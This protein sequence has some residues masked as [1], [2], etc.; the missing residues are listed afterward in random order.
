MSQ[1]CNTNPVV[2]PRGRNKR[3]WNTKEK[4]KLS[5]LT[6]EVNERYRRLGVL[7][8]AV[9]D[10]EAARIAAYQQRVAHYEETFAQNAGA[11]AVLDPSH[12][13]KLQNFIRS[14][15]GAKRTNPFNTGT[16]FNQAGE[17]AQNLLD[18]KRVA[19]GMVNDAGMMRTL[20]RLNTTIDNIRA[21]L[22]HKGIAPDKLGETVQDVIEM[23]NIPKLRLAF[24]KSD[25]VEAFQMKRLGD[26]YQR[27]D[28]LGFDGAETDELVKMAGDVSASFD[29]MRAV[30]DSVGYNIPEL[31]NLGYF[32]RIATDDWRMRLKQHGNEVAGADLSSKLRSG[33]ILSTDWDK[34]RN[35]YWYVPSDSKIA[36]EFLRITPDELDAMILDPIAFRN[37]LGENTTE[38]Q[39][40]DLFDSGVMSKLPMSGRETFEYFVDKFQLPYKGLNEMFLVDPKRAIEAY[41]NELK[42]AVGNHAMVKTVISD[43]IDA[44]WILPHNTIQNLPV[45]QQ[46]N[47]VRL[48]SLEDRLKSWYDTDTLK[49]LQTLYVHRTVA[50]QWMSILHI[51][52]SPSQLGNIARVW[53]HITTTLN[54]SALLGTN[55]LYLGR[56]FLGAV[57]SGH[58]AGADLTKMLPAMWDVANLA[59]KGLEHFDNT[60]PFLKADGK[61]MT[62]REAVE[63]FMLK[64][65]TDIVPGTP[66]VKTGGGF[67]KSDLNPLHHIMSAKKALSDLYLY[68]RS[69]GDPISGAKG[70]T[71]YS[72]MQA[73]NLINGAY[74]PI[75]I[76]GNIIDLAA[77]WSVF[78]SVLEQPSGMA[79]IRNAGGRALSF[80]G[81]SFDNLEAAFRHIDEYFPMYDEIGSVQKAVGGIFQFGVYA[82]QNPPMMLRHALRHPQKYIAYHRLLQM[83]NQAN[84][85][86]VPEGGIPDYAQ[87]DYPIVR[88][89][90][91]RTG[92][93]IL[94][95]PNGYDP[96]TEAF[97]NATELG[98]DVLRFAGRKVGTTNEQIS[99]EAGQYLP[100]R[101][102][103]GWLELL[104]KTFAGK[105]WNTAVGNDPITGEKKYTG[106]D[107]TYL[108]VPMSNSVE[109]LL[110]FV[111]P[112][113]ALNRTNPFDV[114][115]RK[116]RKDAFGNVVVPEK[117][118]FAGFSRTENDDKKYTDDKLNNVNDPVLRT[119]AAFG[120]RVRVADTYKNMDRT[121]SQLERDGN[122]LE[123][124][125]TMYAKEFMLE[126]GSMSPQEQKQHQ[127]K[128]EHMLDVMAQIRMDEARVNAWC[129]QRNIPSSEALQ[130]MKEMRIVTEQLPS[131]ASPVM[132]RITAEILRKR[133]EYFGEDHSTQLKL[134]EGKR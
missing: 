91:K 28:D 45:D 19:T 134:L 27:M 113:D 23:G 98:E 40:N 71:E 120:G 65:G 79:A 84:T 53:S 46:K 61:W 44:G 123:Q 4:Q 60:K 54:K 66:G 59:I 121:F 36:A 38:A 21:Q 39:L 52:S 99:Q 106:G 89:I 31:E 7:G 83:Y 34:M 108:G 82:M 104:S 50:D 57:I 37:W 96:I 35:T 8:G 26:F 6:K 95:S 86:E 126:K 5:G 14:T 24:Q 127:D 80:G 10:E 56:L 101:E 3:Q 48:G 73:Q 32:P 68:T 78:Q 125:A 49:T 43:G 17:V 111:T 81:K 116:E 1:F 9:A 117:K 29:E 133:Q 132:R 109:N 33:N 112:I 51:S 94:L 13:S 100:D 55:V 12:Y 64:R 122:E 69:F 75:A 30:A 128:L 62:K 130:K 105:L 129:L 67:N 87:D 76:S 92:E 97:T 131:P 118:S 20:E 107:N 72:L 88:Q 77:K 103:K 2:N 63:K 115:G 58:A 22:K 16:K 18:A 42:T 114:F 102:D 41:A 74:K 90:D 110:A 47:F 70:F 25:A 11:M 15:F 119:I 93:V 124:K 85:D